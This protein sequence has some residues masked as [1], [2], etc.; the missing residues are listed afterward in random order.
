MHVTQ[1][2]LLISK[3]SCPVTSLAFKLIHAPSLRSVE[4]TKLYPEGKKVKV[5]W[6]MVN[7][8]NPTLKDA[9]RGL[10]DDRPPLCIYCHD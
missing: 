9:G 5:I 3:Y 2:Y 8:F 7:S 4:R 6:I 10:A 1:E